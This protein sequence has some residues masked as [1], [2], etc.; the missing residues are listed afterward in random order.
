MIKANFS[1]RRQLLEKVLK[2]LDPK[3]P[4]SFIESRRLKI[5]DPNLKTIISETFKKAIELR[6]EGVIIKKDQPYKSGSRTV[7]GKL[8]L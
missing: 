7:W 1:V 4:I 6:L 3:T 5:N 8:K 2:T